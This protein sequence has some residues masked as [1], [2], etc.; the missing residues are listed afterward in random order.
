MADLLK[1]LSWA[2]RTERV[3]EMLLTG[4]LKEHVVSIIAVPRLE[5]LISATK[6]RM[7]RVER[8]QVTLKMTHANL[9]SVPTL[10]GHAAPYLLKAAKERADLLSSHYSGLAEIARRVADPE[11]AFCCELNRIGVE[12]AATMMKIVLESNG[13]GL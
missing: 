3:V 2:W 7:A 12:E 11:V 1:H 5:E 6:S 13:V 8:Q 10:V 4:I 9:V